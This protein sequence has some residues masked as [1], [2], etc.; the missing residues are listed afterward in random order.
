M[1]SLPSI[2]L[3][4][5]RSRAARRNLGGFKKMRTSKFLRIIISSLS[6]FVVC[7][8][9]LYAFVWG[10]GFVEPGSEQ[11]PTWSNVPGVHMRGDL[12]L[13]WSVGDGTGEV[14]KQQ[15]Y[16][17]GFEPV[18][19]I[20]SYADYPNNQKENMYPL[21]SNRPHNPWAKPPQFERIVRR[22]IDIADKNRIFI[23]D[24]ELGYEE[25]ATKAWADPVT[26]AMSNTGSFDEFQ[27]A[28]YSEWASWFALPLKWAKEQRPDAKVGIY[29]P[30]AFRRD[31][32]GI[33]GKTAKQI[34]GSHSSDERIWQ[35]IDNYVDFYISSIYIFYN[36]PDSVYY[37]AANVE[38]NYLRS[39]GN[40]PVYP[41]VWLRYHGSSLLEGSREVDPYLVEAMAIVPFFSGAR[42]LAL[43]GYE[44]QFKS[45][46]SAPYRRL[47][48]FM[49]S[50]ARVASLSEQ[51]SRGKLVLDEPAHVLWNS[52]RP[53]IRRVETSANECVVMIVDPWQ[54]DAATSNA[55][56]RCGD[57]NFT[58]Q[59]KGRHITLALISGNET[60]LY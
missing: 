9:A 32:W 47:P 24:I 51:I 56:V 25:D 12:R 15:A 19:I 23:H 22:N 27:Q 49:S 11:Y 5:D 20:N 1:A 42:G 33:A 43:F 45:I 55:D 21:I 30:Q 54:E 4:D 50:L 37:M 17:R 31:Y 60:V 29:G 6:A 26:R 36:K 35:Y 34:D 39:R 40:R 2:D 13:F 44:P 7:Y 41:Y 16:A 58:L 38:E 52:R 28:Y 53:L 8:I 18:T 57:K 59:M 10:Q 46:D 14:N 3:N 48:L